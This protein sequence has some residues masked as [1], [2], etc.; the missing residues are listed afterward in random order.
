MSD[1]RYFESMVRAYADDLFRYAFF[2]S[3]DRHTAE[4]L[5]QETFMLAY[6]NLH[7]LRDPAAT[8]PWLITSMRRHYLR[9]FVKPWRSGEF[10][11]PIS[12]E[13]EE[14]VGVSHFSDTGS[15]FVD[16]IDVH[17]RLL[18]LPLQLREPL[19]LQILF[20]HSIREIAQM[21][22]IGEQA[23]QARIHRARLKLVDQPKSNPNIVSLDK[24]SR[25]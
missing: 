13:D 8:K 22:G 18:A 3:G 23:A 7:Q 21:V 25:R 19:V 24:R 1:S 10:Q 16:L 6:S 11:N 20:G 14:I 4:D 9:A 5:T 17:N 12:L 15:E 2:L